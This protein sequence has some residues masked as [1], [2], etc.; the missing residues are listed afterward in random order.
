MVNKE[1]ITVPRQDE[2]NIWLSAMAVLFQ[3]NQFKRALW[4]N[5]AII[6]LAII[7]GMVSNVLRTQH[8]SI[9]GDWSNE[10]RLVTDSGDTL[11]IPLEEAIK[12]FKEKTAIFY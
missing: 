6:V 1:Q 5:P 9:I 8:L 7:L 10:G 2:L 3:I 12:L 11:V 4:Q